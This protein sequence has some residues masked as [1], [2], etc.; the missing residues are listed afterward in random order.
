MRRADLLILH[1]FP[2]RESPF[3]RF[4]VLKITLWVVLA[5]ALSACQSAPAQLAKWQQ[6][7]H[8]C[9]EAH[10]WG[11]VWS[12]DSSGLAYA[13]ETTGLGD[14][15]VVNLNTR[16]THSLNVPFNHGLIRGGPMDWSSQGKLL[17]DGLQA[18]IVNRDG[19]D[20]AQLSAVPQ[21][22]IFGA[23]WSPDGS[24]IAYISPD[25]ARADEQLSIFDV[26]S[27]SSTTI[28]NGASLLHPAWSPDGQHLAVIAASTN[29][30]HIIQHLSILMMNSDGSEMRQVTHEIDVSAFVWS[31]SGDQIAFMIYS[32][33]QI[34]IYVISANGTGQQ[35]L[36]DQAAWPFV[37]LPDGTGL[38]ASLPGSTLNTMDITR[39]DLDATLSTLFTMT[40][41]TEQTFSPGGTK[42]A[43]ISD[44]QGYLDVY[45][46]NVDGADK[47]QITHNPAYSNCFDWPF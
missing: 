44:D 14:S 12:P 36:F 19:S 42:I 26:A 5:A 32:G 9:P 41:P 46:M 38:I 18:V 25:P 31:P 43:Y 15:F 13:A 22:A 24:Q 34:G 35:R 28:F 39:I 2:L 45:V 29:P 30:T 6:A 27:G 33:P 37:W 23:A 40:T 20:W 8:P 16:S 7:F 21:P 4:S 11:L 47:M 17:L 10:Y 1:S 3:L